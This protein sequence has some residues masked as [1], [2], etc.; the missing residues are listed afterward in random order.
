MV[1][2]EFST[3]PGEQVELPGI[4]VCCAATE[5]YLSNAVLKQRKPS[6]IVMILLFVERDDDCQT[7]Q[8]RQF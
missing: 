5:R 3:K 1:T 7:I 4:R 6:I 8:S 2:I